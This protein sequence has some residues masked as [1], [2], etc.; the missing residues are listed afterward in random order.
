MNHFYCEDD[1]CIYFHCGK[2]GHRNDALKKHDK[3][4][5]CVFDEGYRNENDWALNIRSVIVFG[6]IELIDNIDAVIEISEKLSRKFTDDEAYIQKE[7]AAF[8]SKTLLLKLV[9]EN[10]C[11]KRVKE[12]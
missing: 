8:A 10:I 3:V 12:S 2:T 7:I 11:G 5:F 1:G 6:K 4:S 9:P